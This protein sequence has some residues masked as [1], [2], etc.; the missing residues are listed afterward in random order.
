M[1]NPGTRAIARRSLLAGA[2]L[3]AQAANAALKLP[4][5]VRLALLGLEGHTGEVVRPLPQL[6]D[7]EVAAIADPNGSAIAAMA[8]NPRLAGA[9]RYADYR[10]MLERE[11]LDMVCICGPTHTR[12]ERILACAERKLHVVAEKPLAIERADLEKVK[13]AVGKS[14]I[15]LTML[16]PMRFSPPYLALRQIVRE[17][18]IGE[19]AQIAAQKSYK[20]GKRPTWMLKRAS[21]GGSIPYIGIHMVDLMRWSTGREMVQAASFQSHIG[22]PEYGDMENTTGTIFRLD[23]GGVG[24]LRMDYLRPETAASHGDDRLRV[25]GTVGVV[26]YQAS[27]GVTLISSKEKPRTISSLPPAGS[28]FLDFLDSV[29]HAKPPMLDLPDIYR[30]NEIVLAARESAE[31]GRVIEV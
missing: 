14:G 13:A 8:R 11:E 12:A 19:V 24:M 6:P 29:Y 17:G 4:R 15:R 31:K 7:V 23:N 9:K 2:A 25:V 5:K 27:T 28:L 18:Q 3:A 22:F 20:L 21:F 1:H 26:E 16:L 10:Q 30:V